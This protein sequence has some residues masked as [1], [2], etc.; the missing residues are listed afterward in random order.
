MDVATVRAGISHYQPETFNY[1]LK[2]LQ[3]WTEALIDAMALGLFR[4]SQFHLAKIQCGL[5]GQ[6]DYQLRDGI[7]PL[8][9]HVLP[10]IATAPSDIIAD[11]RPGALHAT[12]PIGCVYL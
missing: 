5:C 2:R 3:D 6:G 8:S 1:I 9:S 12:S 4:L 7:T 10:S 11:I